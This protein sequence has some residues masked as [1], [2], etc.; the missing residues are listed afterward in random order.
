MNT[1]AN[2]P[3]MMTIREVASTGVLSEYA[4]RQL[5]KEGRLPAIHVGTKALINY[6]KLCENLNSLE[7]KV[8][9]PEEE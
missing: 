8:I 7:S 3:R 6:D 9:V 4:L 5:L 1:R 2:A